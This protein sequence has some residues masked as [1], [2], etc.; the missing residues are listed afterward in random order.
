M[1]DKLKVCINTSGLVAYDY[2]VRN[3]PI[4]VIDAL[5]LKE[6]GYIMEANDTGFTFEEI[7]NLVETGNPEG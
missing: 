4:A 7:A 2:S 6:Y 3:P 5:G 1:A